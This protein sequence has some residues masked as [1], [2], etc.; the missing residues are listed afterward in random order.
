MP[1]RPKEQP[2]L[3]PEIFFYLLS[4]QVALGSAVL[5][6]VQGMAIVTHFMLRKGIA[7][8]TGRLVTT[9]FLL[10]F[11][12]PGV[13]LLVVFVLPL[14]GVTETWIVYRRNE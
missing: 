3:G 4:L 12:I 8:N 11:L 13:N 1:V 14:L 5:Y 2:S 9:T 10:A 6:A 7:V